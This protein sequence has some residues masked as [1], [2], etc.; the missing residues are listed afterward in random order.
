MPKLIAI[1]NRADILP[2]RAVGAELIEVQDERQA[3]TALNGI[4]ES[5]EP[6]VVMITE[7]M[8][9]AGAQEIEELR[10]SGKH[11]FLPIPTI[12]TKPGKRLE[13]IRSLVARA[14]GVDLLGRKEA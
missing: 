9:T 13:E 10:K 8:A 5:E 3:G 14:L 11:V 7:G 4:R 12:H 1:G 6:A 2:F